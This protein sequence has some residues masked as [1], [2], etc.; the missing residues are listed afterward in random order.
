MDKEE[1]E[2]RFPCGEVESSFAD[3]IVVS[4]VMWLIFGALATWSLWNAQRGGTWSHITMDYIIIIF[5]V[6]RMTRQRRPLAY[7]AEEGLVIR[8]RPVNLFERIDMLVH[9]DDYYTFVPYQQIMGFT[10]NW[11]EIHMVSEQGGILIVVVDLQF[12]KYS[13][14][15]ALLKIID[16]RSHVGRSDS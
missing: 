10:S 16:E 8:R 14:K 6:W 13:D 5:C 3:Y 2:Q 15:M 4:W 1:V 9:G 11:E 12:M 7:V